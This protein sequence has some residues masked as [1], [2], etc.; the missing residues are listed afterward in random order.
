MRFLLF[1]L[2]FIGTSTSK[3]QWLWDVGGN[4]GASSY[5]GDIGGD[6]KTRR[7]FVSDLKLAKTRWNVGGFVRHKWRRKLS[8]KFG[9]DYIRLEGDDKLSSNPGRQYRNFNFRN[10]IFDISYKMEYNFYTNTDLGNT[11][12]YQNSFR[13]YGFVG[14][15]VFYNNPRTLYQGAYVRLQ[16]LATEGYNYRKFVMNIPMGVGFYFTHNK[17][18]RFGYEI[19]YRKTFTDYIDDISGNYPSTPPP[20]AYE[21]GLILRTTELDRAS[22]IGAYDSH[23]WGMKRGDPEHKDA[24]VTMTLS[25]SRVIR[26]KASFHRVRNVGFFGKKN[27]GRVVRA[28]F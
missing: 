23:T 12:R 17:R 5:L 28:K 4:I 10:D 7:D 18:H 15:G 21:Q 26:G 6:E 25:Y 1:F 14:A 16:P 3:S 24:Y 22:N 20:S 13:A 11:Y 8:W 19:N 2:F 9:I 27:K